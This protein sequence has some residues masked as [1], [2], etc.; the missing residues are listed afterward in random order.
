MPQKLTGFFL[1]AGEG[2]GQDGDGSH[3]QATL[4]SP[5]SSCGGPQRPGFPSL[6]NYEYTPPRSSS[7]ASP[8]K[9][10]PRRDDDIRGQK[11]R[12]PFIL[13]PPDIQHP[14][15]IDNFPASDQHISEQTMKNMLISLKQTLYSDLSATVFFLATVLQHQDQRL[16]HVENKMSD[17]FTAYNDI[18]DACTEHEDEMQ[19]INLKL[20]DLQV[21]SRRNNIR[22]LM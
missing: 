19:A 5:H 20:A 4:P 22:F 13:P 8:M 12:I 6:A 10:R 11:P 17:L 15:A 21:R 9:S 18:V 3:R 7:S 2:R 1:L 16:Q 14:S